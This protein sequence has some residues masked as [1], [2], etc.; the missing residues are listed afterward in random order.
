MKIEFDIDANTVAAFL[1]RSN[2]HALEPRMVAIT[3]FNAFAHSAPTAAVG[4]VAD[5]C[6]S[7]SWDGSQIW[8]AVELHAAN[9]AR[10]GLAPEI[11][12]AE[13]VRGVVQCR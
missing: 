10:A 7:G 8:K 6:R 4:A 1:Q 5:A 13:A 11:A 9:G 3:L 2:H 12:P